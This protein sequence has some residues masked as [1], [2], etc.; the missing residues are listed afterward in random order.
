MHRGDILDAL[1]FISRG[2]IEVLKDDVVMAIL[3]LF[4]VCVLGRAG[5]TLVGAH[6]HIFGG[7]PWFY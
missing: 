6:V 7:G 4:L 1:Y 2:S 5:F 3:G